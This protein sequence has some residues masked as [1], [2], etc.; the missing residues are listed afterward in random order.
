M[1]LATLMAGG[2]VM[3]DKKVLSQL[4]NDIPNF[5]RNPS[6]CRIVRFF[7]FESPVDDASYRGRTFS[8][9]GWRGSK[10]STLKSLLLKSA[11]A[12][13]KDHYH[14]CPKAQLESFFKLSENFNCE[15]CVFLVGDGRVIES[16]FRSIRNALAHGSFDVRKYK[17]ER[18]FRART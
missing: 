1:Y 17:G 18:R 4:S 10:F 16:L 11:T 6:F 9:Q 7:L 5:A 15:Y 13:L 8:K 14:P 2:N 12:E 3:R